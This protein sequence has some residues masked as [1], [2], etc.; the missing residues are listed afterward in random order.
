VGGALVGDRRADQPALARQGRYQHVA[1]NL[2]VK[3]VRIPDTG[4]R[5]VV[6]YNPDQARRDRATRQR[7]VVRLQEAIAGSDKLSATKRAE[8]RGQISTKPDPARL[9]RTTLG[10]LLRLD[11]AAIAAEAKLDGAYL[12]RSSDPKLSAEGIALGYK[13]LLW[14]SNPAGGTSTSSR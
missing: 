3:E 2:Q 4:E 6:C 13:R 12:L 10:G 8:L 5:F 11:K 9:V 1:D 14:R 7:L